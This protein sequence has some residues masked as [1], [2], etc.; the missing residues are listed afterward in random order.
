MHLLNA[1]VAVAAALTGTFGASV[2][3]GALNTTP[4][5]PTS[6]PQEPVTLTHYLPCEPPASLKKGVCVTTVV[7]KVV[8]TAEPIVT[9]V[10]EKSRTPKATKSSPT[11]APVKDDDHD[12]YEGED[13]GEQE[14]EGD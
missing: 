8:K 10:V 1:A 9:T 4:V 14:H 3:Y 7:K 11:T 12:E 6:Q 13:E 5:G 2:A